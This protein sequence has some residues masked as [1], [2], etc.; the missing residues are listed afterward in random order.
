MLQLPFAHLNLTRNPFGEFSAEERGELAVV[1]LKCFFPLLNTPGFA[2]QILGEQGR[3]KSTH[4][5]AIKKHFP[6]APYIYY[7]EDG[8]KP[9][10]PR[11]PVLFLDEMQRFSKRE[12]LQIFSRSASFVVASHRNHDNEFHKTKLDSHSIT[13]RGM[14]TDRLRQILEKRLESCRRSEGTIPYFEEASLTALIRR[15]GDDLR[16]MEEY[17][18]HLFQNLNAPT[19]IKISG[20]RKGDYAQQL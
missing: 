18:Y 17:L 15:F 11:A 6:G 12:R 4:L 16:S 7:P 2:L 13:L 14:D 1:E 5:H 10:V 3:G 9:E 20:T 19:S 8:P